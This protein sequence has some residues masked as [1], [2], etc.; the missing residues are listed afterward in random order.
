MAL[1]VILSACDDGLSGYVTSTANCSAYLSCDT[2]TPVAGCGWCTGPGG[3]GVCA[4]DP[5]YCPTQ[6][7]S[8]TWDINGC[9]VAADASVVATDD[10]SSEGP[11]LDSASRPD[12]AR[13][14]SDA[15]GN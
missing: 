3:A 2:C 11:S 14:S 1:T 12:G 5:D 4:S 9:R 8:W 6:E 15:S 7:F 13:S 10:G